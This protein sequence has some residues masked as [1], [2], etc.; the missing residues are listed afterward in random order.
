MRRLFLIPLVLVLVLGL[1]LSGCAKPAPAPLVVE[2]DENGLSINK[3]AFNM[4]STLDDY[5][6]V[7]GFPPRV[8]ELMNTIYTYDDVGIRLYQPP[9]TNRIISVG[10][11]FSNL[12]Y[13]F[14]P[15]H[16][17]R[18]VL[19]VSQLSI[20]PT[21]HSD[22]L[23]SI[24]N[25]IVEDL[26]F[27]VYRGTLGSIILHFDYRE[28]RQR[29]DSLAISFSESSS[30]STT[31]SEPTPIE[32]GW[33][34]IIIKD[35][36]SIDYPT[37]FLELQS[38][39]YRGG[40]EEFYQ[41]MELSTS[42]FTLQQLGLNELKPSAL[43]EYRRV[44]FQT[45]F[46]NLGEEV[47]KANEKYTL[48]REELA[49]FE[50][51]LID[52]LLQGF[53]MGKNRGWENKLVESVS[54]EIKEVNGMFPMVHTYKRQLDDNPVVLVKTYLFWNYDRI[55]S[56]AFSCRVVD[57]EECQDIYKKILDSFRLQ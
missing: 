22:S 17:F 43:D 18:G 37:D 1:I 53:K 56:L 38:G 49:E 15:R 44:V 41:I 54:L 14:S 25:L 35:V 11:D 20:E 3:N 16:T 52:Q 5:I 23:N 12:S 29:L 47:F 36:G 8:T 55:H 7:L 10:I 42:D 33:A 19:I 24:P 31:P 28:S 27:G 39:E 45:S 9:D 48:S 46:L 40:I 50:N 51:A 30:E 34:R 6:R 26:E 57:E 32:Q 4:D 21:L 13:Q 2:V